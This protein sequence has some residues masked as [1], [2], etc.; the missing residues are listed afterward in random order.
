MLTEIHRSSK[1]LLV[2]STSSKAELHFCLVLMMGLKMKIRILTE[3]PPFILLHSPEAC[4]RKGPL[5]RVQHAYSRGIAV[6]SKSAR[7]NVLPFVFPVTISVQ[8]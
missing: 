8:N 1:V 6:N 2:Y 4:R 5:F 7:Q 3:K